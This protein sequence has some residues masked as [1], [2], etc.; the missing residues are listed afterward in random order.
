V[1]SLG[2]GSGDC[3]RNLANKFGAGDLSIS[4]IGVYPVPLHT[5]DLSQKFNRL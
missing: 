1:S 2:W 5:V 4:S 3:G